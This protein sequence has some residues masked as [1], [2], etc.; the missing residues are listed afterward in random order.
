MT[1]KFIVSTT[2]ASAGIFIPSS[3]KIFSFDLSNEKIQVNPIENYSEIIPEK[4]PMSF[5]FDFEE[6]NEIILE[7]MKKES[8]NSA[9]KKYLFSFQSLKKVPYLI[10]TLFL[11]N[12]GLLKVE[13]DLKTKEIKAFDR[14]SFFD[15][16]KVIKKK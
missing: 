6:I 1:S 14:K 2:L 3:K 5:N 16:L 9:I 7:K 12:M 10:G 11:Q 4:I 13:I 8:L 15:V